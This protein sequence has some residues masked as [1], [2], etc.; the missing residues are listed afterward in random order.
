MTL[1]SSGSIGRVYQKRRGMT[2]E[3]NV[4]QGKDGAAVQAYLADR[5]FALLVTL[6]ALRDGG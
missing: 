2:T 4:E 3:N 1:P 5:S 6:R